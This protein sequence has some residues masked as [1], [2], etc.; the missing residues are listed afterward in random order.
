[1]Q[2]KSLAAAT[3]I[4]LCASTQAM[5][6][7]PPIG[8]VTQRALLA[9]GSAVEMTVTPGTG[10][11]V[12][13]STQGVT[14][15]SSDLHC[16]YVYDGAGSS[17]GQFTIPTGSGKYWW[18]PFDRNDQPVLLTAGR[19]YDVDCACGEYS[20]SAEWD[21]ASL[22]DPAMLY[23]SSC[24]GGNAEMEV[25]NASTGQFVAAGSGMIFSAG[26]VVFNGVT[27]Q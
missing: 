5:R 3:L 19:T 18:V 8:N 9:N 17:T 13:V 20:Y 21:G 25:T 12:I 15:Q 22:F 6:S 26:S 24:T 2:F 10:G 16:L 1:M 14:A 4:L 11:S 27:Y 23:C 7:N